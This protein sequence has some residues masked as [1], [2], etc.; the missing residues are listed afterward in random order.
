[1]LKLESWTWSFHKALTDYGYQVVH[2]AFFLPRLD[3]PCLQKLAQHKMTQPYLNLSEDPRSCPSSG[4]M[5][6]TYFSWFS[7]PSWPVKSFLATPAHVSLIRF[8]LR[9]R[10]GSHRL[11]IVTGR[12]HAVPRSQRFCPLCS[13]GS[14]CDEQH[15]VF[16]CPCLSS[17]RSR[18]PGVFSPAI[19]TMKQF[20]WQKD[21]L[22]VML[23]LRECFQEILQ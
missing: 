11:P 21:I 6:C 19:S 17:I 4:A 15:V 16:E 23:F 22:K 12:F 3:K 8:F 5:A 1:M 18:Y 14:V 10:T 7:K 13:D 20:V 2:S 9:F